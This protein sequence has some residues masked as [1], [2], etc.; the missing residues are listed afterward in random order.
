MTNLRNPQDL[1]ERI[2]HLVQEYIAATRAAAHA[3][4]E[5]AL[6]TPAGVEAKRPRQERP[7]ARA[8]SG[9]V[10]TSGEIGALSERLYEAVCKM[11][12]ET[13]TVLAPMI[14]TTASELSRPMTVLKATG[15][16]RSVGMRH[17]T[18]YFPMASEAQ[19]PSA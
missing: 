8:R 9:V 7:V 15:R 17:M 4:V 2:E 18:R 1:C 6:A 10:R 12:G 14:G 5:R 19:R 13:M 3:A 16:V 11:P